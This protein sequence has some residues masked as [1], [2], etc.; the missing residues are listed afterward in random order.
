MDDL[1]SR[2]LKARTKKGLTQTQLAKLVGVRQS[3]IGN[4]ESRQRKTSRNL[5]AIAEVLDVSPL[6]LETGKMQDQRASAP[7][8]S[9]D[10]DDDL[11]RVNAAERRLVRLYREA[12]DIAREKILMEAE[13]SEKRLF[14]GLRSHKA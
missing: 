3:T 9:A 8:Q 2:L 12:S 5:A 4:L 6:Y 13:A 10:D 11:I 14:T 1:A 7:V